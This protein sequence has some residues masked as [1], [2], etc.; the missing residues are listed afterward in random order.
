MAELELWRPLNLGGSLNVLTLEPRCLGD[1]QLL[2][3]SPLALGLWSLIS[4]VQVPWG[5]CAK[6]PE[7][8]R[9]GIPGLELWNYSF[10]TQVPWCCNNGTPEH[11][12]LGA[13]QPE[14]WS[15][16]SGVSIPWYRETGAP[17]LGSCEAFDNGLVC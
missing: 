1:A 12:R 6:I 17:E 3:R 11:P 16:G 4:G 8:F 14:L 13:L 5:C 9:L 15:G 2:L 7:L 10:G